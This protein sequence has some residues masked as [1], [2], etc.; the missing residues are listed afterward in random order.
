[1]EALKVVPGHTLHPVY[2]ELCNA[3]DYYII[4]N[5]LK[6]F[7]DMDKDDQIVEFFTRDLIA[8]SEPR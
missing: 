3:I 8:E 2:G 4:M 7:F 5:I 6:E 1:M